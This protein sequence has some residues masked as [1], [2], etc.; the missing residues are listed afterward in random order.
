MKM[1]FESMRVALDLSLYGLQDRDYSSFC[2]LW[3]SLGEKEEA[4]WLI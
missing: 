2:F 3:F 1:H 4:G